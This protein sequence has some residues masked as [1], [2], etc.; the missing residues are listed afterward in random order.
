MHAYVILGIIVTLGVG[1][2][3]AR[4]II[5]KR[6]KNRHLLQDFFGTLSKEFKRAWTTHYQDSVEKATIA[7]AINIKIRANMGKRFQ[8]MIPKMGY[9]FPT[10]A[11]F[12]VNHPETDRYIIAMYE[13]LKTLYKEHKRFGAG[14]DVLE[15]EFYKQSGKAILRELETLKKGN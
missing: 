9:F 12:F 3:Y 2:A 13:E 1:I 7:K 11:I 10:A 14:E 15:D 5:K 6:I 4:F 8:I